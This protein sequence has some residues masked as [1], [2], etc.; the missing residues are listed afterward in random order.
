MPNFEYTCQQCSKK[1]EITKRI[2]ENHPTIHFEADPLAE[3]SGN[4]EQTLYASPVHFHA[5]G[6]PGNDGRGRR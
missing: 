4:L 3:C 5:A 6:F 2:S 1:I